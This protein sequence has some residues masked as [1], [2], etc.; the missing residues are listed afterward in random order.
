MENKGNKKAL[1]KAQK[2]QRLIAKTLGGCV[3]I[4]VIIVCGILYMNYQN[5]KNRFNMT[6]KEGMKEAVGLELNTENVTSVKLQLEKYK[7]PCM[8]S[9]T[10][11]VQKLLEELCSVQ[12][13]KINVRDEDSGSFG[14]GIQICLYTNKERIV[15]TTRCNIG[16]TTNA[17]SI[18]IDDIEGYYEPKEDIEKIVEYAM[19]QNEKNIKELTLEEVKKLAQK[20]KITWSDFEQ[21]QG[22]LSSG[23]YL[24]DTDK[25]WWVRAY[26]DE[27]TEV[28]IPD[29]EPAHI[30]IYSK[31]GG[32]IDIREEGLEIFM[33]EKIEE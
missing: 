9:D 20:E 30:E 18:G 25:K 11:Q 19:E 10:Q 1:T 17:I 28:Y 21:Y 16:K 32:S 14:E 13:D 22:F 8:I 31:K 2:K 4:I 29:E 26:N 15:I 7:Y 33:G 12:V 3:V 5:D 6:L 27:V 24:S 23:Q